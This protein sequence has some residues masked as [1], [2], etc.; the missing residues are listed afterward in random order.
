VNSA[1]KLT[2][3]R[4]SRIAQPSRAARAAAD[5]E[6]QLKVRV[7][8]TLHRAIKVRL[9]ERGISLQDYVLELL[10]KDGLT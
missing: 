4:P 9:A 10:Q 5:G 8:S 7:S 3:Q 1:R 2:L 6:I